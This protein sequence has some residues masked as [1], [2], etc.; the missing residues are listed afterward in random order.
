[1]IFNKDCLNF[2]KNADMIMILIM[3]PNFKQVIIELAD[4][5]KSIE[6]TNLRQQKELEKT[7]KRKNK[8][9]EVFKN[10]SSNQLPQDNRLDFQ[11]QAIQ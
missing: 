9:N 5:Q 1:M 7:L 10:M 3:I 4:F 6:Q 11:I 2:Q 8:N